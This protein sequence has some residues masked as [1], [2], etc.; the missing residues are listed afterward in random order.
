MDAV[1]AQKPPLWPTE[2]RG[3]SLPTCVFSS[4]LFS[5]LISPFF[6][7]LL[8]WLCFLFAPQLLS[9]FLSLVSL[10][11]YHSPINHL[12]L[13][14]PLFRLLCASMAVPLLYTHTLFLHLFSWRVH[15][16]S[17]SRSPTTSTWLFLFL[18]LLLWTLMFIFLFILFF[19]SSLRTLQL[20]SPFCFVSSFFD[21]PPL[22]LYSSCIHLHL[23]P[24]AK[25]GEIELE[26][27]WTS[28][29]E[30][31]WVYREKDASV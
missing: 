7:S 20:S 22:L 19:Y 1:P 10:L 16:T 21:I 2:K 14:L 5:L 27:V 11:W 3:R 4:S 29:E 28:S 12:Q 23:A 31:C 30:K 9:K 8:L 17:F 26:K 25:G 18:F 15:V 24:E 6:L 13:S